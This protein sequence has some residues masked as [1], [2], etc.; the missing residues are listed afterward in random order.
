MNWKEY[1]PEVKYDLSGAEQ[2]QKILEEVQEV[3][4]EGLIASKA[5]LEE[6]VD[7]VHA[8]FNTIYKFGYSTQDVDVMVE[9]VKLKNQAK[10]KYK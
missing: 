7:V 3:Q 6:L 9:F 8:T 1:F 2:Y 10:G 4:D 5:T